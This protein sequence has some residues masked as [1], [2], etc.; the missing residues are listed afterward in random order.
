MQRPNVTEANMQSSESHTATD[1]SDYESATRL[2]N[3]RRRHLCRHDGIDAEPREVARP[4]TS[5]VINVMLHE[6]SARI[7][8]EVHDRTRAE[9]QDDPEI[10]LSNVMAQFQAVMKSYIQHTNRSCE[11][12][13]WTKITEIESELKHQRSVTA[14]LLAEQER[15]WEEQMAERDHHWEERM[16]VIMAEQDRHAKATNPIEREKS[17]G[18]P[19]SSTIDTHTGSEIA[20]LKSHVVSLNIKVDGMHAWMVAE[21]EK[22]L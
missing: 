15:H 7:N 8:E 16:Q 14:A 22:A 21:R 9:S 13:F 19:A 18:E 11:D 12:V 5:E 20:R 3:K 1:G 4:G 17:H 6:R 10:A 2:N